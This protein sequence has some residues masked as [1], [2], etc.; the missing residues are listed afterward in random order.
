[1]TFDDYLKPIQNDV[2]WAIVDWIISAG[3]VPHFFFPSISEKYEGKVIA[4]SP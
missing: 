3:F 1:M 2:K 4:K